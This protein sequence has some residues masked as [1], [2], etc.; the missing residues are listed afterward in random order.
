MEERYNERH[1]IDPEAPRQVYEIGDWVLVKNIAK[2]KFEYPW[3]GPLRVETIT[4]FGAYK[5]I[6]PDGKAKMDLVHKD[7]LK[8]V[9]LP[10][11]SPEPT[12]AWYKTRNSRDEL[13]I[14]METIQ[15][16][17]ER[18]PQ[19]EPEVGTAVQPIP[20]EGSSRTT[21]PSSSAR[22]AATASPPPARP[23]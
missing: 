23:P 22:P 9:N 16:E 2:R 19:S 4:P 13:T 11:G 6:W 7:R 15:E 14:P 20:L 18:G 17:D 21:A 1:D 3:Y 8:P 12:R 10:A 5:L